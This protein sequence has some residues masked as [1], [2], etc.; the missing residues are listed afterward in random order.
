MSVKR[1]DDDYSEEDVN[2]FDN[3]KMQLILR[4]YV[5]HL[6]GAD[7]QHAVRALQLC[8]KHRQQHETSKILLS[9]G[10]NASLTL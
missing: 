8:S 9:T 4:E 6:R 7:D 3:V 10:T 2:P 5:E 1:K